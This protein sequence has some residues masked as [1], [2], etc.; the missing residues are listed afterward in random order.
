MEII[1]KQM[2]IKNFKGINHKLLH[3]NNTCTLYG[4]NG[5]GKTTVFDAFMWL[6][7]GKDSK[8]RKDFAL[9]GVNPDG[10]V[11]EK[12]EH[13][14]TAI[15]YVDGKPIKLNS[16]L[17]E[18]WSSAKA[19]SEPTLKGNLTTYS[20][21]DMP[22]KQEDYRRKI[23]ELVDEEVFKII[24]SPDY[25]STL[26]WQKS[27]AILCSMADK[28]DDRYIIGSN[29]ELHN[30][31]DDINGLDIEDY[32]KRL[33]VSKKKLTEEFSQI[34]SR[35]DE[36]TLSIP[37]YE[38]YT[39][40]DELLTKKRS[41]L[42]DLELDIL[43]NCKLR[44]ND[45]LL[46]DSQLNTKLLALKNNAEQKYQAD[47]LELTTKLNINRGQLSEKKNNKY[48]LEKRHTQLEERISRLETEAQALTKALK[49]L[50]DDVFNPQSNIC[51]VC[52]REFDEA[53]KAE[54]Y[55]NYDNNKKT[56]IECI[57]NKALAIASELSQSYRDR[58]TITLEINTATLQIKALEESIYAL[59]QEI[60]QLKRED[61]SSNPEFIAI[62]NKLAQLNTLSNTEHITALENAREEL[63][64]EIESLQARLL[65]KNNAERAHA[66]L[67][68][69]KAKETA[70]NNDI[71]AIDKKLFSLQ[72]L[73]LLRMKALETSINSRF[74]LVKFKLYEK[75]INE[76]IAECCIP[77]IN[78]VPY[79]DLN[80]AAKINCGIDIINTLC[81]YY[82][83][84]APIF[85]DNRESIT[86]LIPS[87]SQTIGLMV[88]PNSELYVG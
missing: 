83:V 64:S 34:P 10:S 77:T 57:N 51:P 18:K 66:R 76:S 81:R 44:D 42:Q 69:L 54:L 41:E 33:L 29:K 48:S 72:Q 36:V 82:N 11:I 87:Q 30:L 45:T 55:A 75:L 59:E 40:L 63:S 74:S 80:G 4:E 32:K 71:V 1:L 2:E 84:Y 67:K 16:T 60:S 53:K 68:D 8:N 25:F 7:F 65:L 73:V 21:D 26:H 61:I 23:S 79:G 43:N 5:S 58:D 70:L 62:S 52:N 9:K 6:L 56:N 35:I 85:I 19:S 20:I 28:I 13:S 27:R 88:K 86:Q 37:P 15:L 46:L 17:K 24:T 47:K 14:V 3:F 49:N 39:A 38:D 12:L 50:E 78:G 22:L 31:L